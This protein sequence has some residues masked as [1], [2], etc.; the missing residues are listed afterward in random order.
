MVSPRATPAETVEQLFTRGNQALAARDLTTAALAYRTAL[1]IDPTQAA[2][3]GNLALAL[4]EAGDVQA[5]DHHYRQAL[6]LEPDQAQLWINHGVL[7]LQGK[8]LREAEAA[9]RQ[10]LALAPNDTSALS[11]LG[12]L[13]AQQY[14]DEEAETTL[15]T[16]LRLQPQHRNAAY[17]LAYLLL[18]QCRLEEG[19]LRLEQRDRHGALAERLAK[20]LPCPRWR[21]EPLQGRSLLIALEAGHG[22]MIHFCRYAALAK[23]AGARRVTV[24]CH[25]ALVTLFATLVGCDQA[26]PFDQDLP[27]GTDGEAP[28]FDYWVP[29][30]SLPY[31]FATRPDTIPATLPYLHADPARVAH[32]APRLAAPPGVLK[33]GLVWK[34][35]VNFEN[36]TER[37]LPS[38]ATLAPLG[39]TT[40]VVF[41]SLQKGAGENEATTPPQELPLTPL[42]GDLVDFADTA[43]VIAQLDLVITVDTAVAHLAGALGQPC[44]LLLPWYLPDWRWFKE[45]EDSPWY[46][47]VLR[48]FRQPAMGDWDSVVAQVAQALRGRAGRH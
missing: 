43:A 34:G 27:E 45:R 21:G 14:R 8:R 10:A 46:P 6:A 13:L 39:Q 25:P 28:H 32:W 5:A 7:L 37:S 42:G 44:W 30:L 29:P 47:G 35:N 19:W 12:V 48:L 11:N 41:Y 31:L 36:D 17:N 2:L 22:D 9:L 40:G 3:H 16:A 1:A 18:R 26:I 15:R 38:L 23:A 20:Q 4:D 24:L 33:V